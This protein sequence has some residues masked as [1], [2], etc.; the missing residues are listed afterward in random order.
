MI[1]PHLG[2]AEHAALLAEAVGLTDGGVDIDRHRRVARTGSGGPGPGQQLAS[3]LV[4]LASV[5]PAERAQERAERR[6]G[7]TPWPST[8]AVSPERSRS[9]SSMQSPPASAEWTR[10]I[11]LRPTLARRPHRRDRRAR[12]RAHA[13]RDAGPVW[14]A[15]S[16]RRWPPDARHRRSRPHGQDCGKIRGSK[17]CLPVGGVVGVVTTIFPCRKALFVDTRP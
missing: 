15:A 10:V 13:G 16:S 8:D 7:R 17:K 2:V 5:P 1:A 12:R 3:H 11:A 4:E 9:A 14:P 6:R